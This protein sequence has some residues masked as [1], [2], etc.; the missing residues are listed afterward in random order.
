ML[1]PIARMTLSPIYKLWLRKIEGLENLP[2]GK[3]FIIA[4]NHAS[5]YDT[6]LSHII[7]IP[8][9]GRQVHALVNRRYWDR[10]LS[11]III[12]WGRA[13]PV[14]V[15]KYASKEKNNESFRKA[16][17]FLK[18]GEIIEIFPEGKRSSDGKLQKAY[19]GVAK[20]AVKSKVPV[21]PIGIR[22]SDK[23]LPRGAI[24]PRF[25][26][27]EFIIGKPIH[28]NKKPS[29]KNYKDITRKIMKEIAKLINQKYNY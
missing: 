24:L 5:Y 16:V 7:I 25:K 1:Y 21:I 12:E 14:Y 28:F 11:R 6:I 3:P 26:R 15:G 22:D 8:K 4:L 2:L 19:T 13:I 10:F 27:A 17:S 29:E 23:V 20:L 18:K 9:T